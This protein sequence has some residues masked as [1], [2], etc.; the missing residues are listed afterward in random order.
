MPCTKI[1]STL[2]GLNLAVFTLPIKTRII[3]SFATIGFNGK[4]KNIATKI[5]VHP[6]FLLGDALTIKIGLKY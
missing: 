3:G 5:I 6:G 1:F 4:M 2:S